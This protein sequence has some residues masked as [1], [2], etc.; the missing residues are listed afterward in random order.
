MNFNQINTDWISIRWINNRN[1]YETLWFNNNLHD[2]FYK[3]M[4]V[5]FQIE[6]NWFN[7]TGSFCQIKLEWQW[8]A[9]KV[10]QGLYVNC[11][12]IVCELFKHLFWSAFC[13]QIVYSRV[14]LVF[15][16]PFAYLDWV[17]HGTLC[18]DIN[19]HSKSGQEVDSRFEIR[20]KVFSFLWNNEKRFKSGTRTRDPEMDLKEKC[21]E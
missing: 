12:R 17:M 20:E 2:L 10:I 5:F 13:L 18:G 15:G 8:V 4:L 6:N 7:E 11:I 21:F 16:A 9:I 14:V 3:I 19:S 1:Q